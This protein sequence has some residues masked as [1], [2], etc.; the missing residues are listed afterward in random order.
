MAVRRWIGGTSTA[1]TTAANWSA[2]TSPVNGDKVIFDSSAENNCVGTLGANIATNVNIGPRF[3]RDIG[4]VSTAVSLQDRFQNQVTSIDM[5][6]GFANLD[7]FTTDCVIRSAPAGDNLYITGS[8]TTCIISGAGGNITFGSTGTLACTTM[9]IAPNK[10]LGP[11]P[12]VKVTVSGG[13]VTTLI[14]CG[15]CEIDWTAA[16]TTGILVGPSLT[17]HL[18][19]DFANTKMVVVDAYVDQDESVPV[20]GGSSGIVISNG[21]LRFLPGI[22]QASVASSGFIDLYKDS[23]LDMH[24]IPTL[25]ALGTITSYGGNVYPR[26]PVT[27]SVPSDTKLSSTSGRSLDFSVAANSGHAPTVLW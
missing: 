17:A 20:V 16:N 18:H 6:K 12:S 15:P 8:I 2:S 25:S 22:T 24:E 10:S 23:A 9:V 1:V 3:E 14:A 21:T 5:T 11:D 27:I 26:R 7:L 13:T 4:T 19:N